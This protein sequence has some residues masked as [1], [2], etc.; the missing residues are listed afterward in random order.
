MIHIDLCPVTRR[1]LCLALTALTFYASALDQSQPPIRILVGAAPGGSTDTLPREMAPAMGRLLGRTVV[2]ENRA[3]AGGNL[4][5]EA[6]AKAAPDGNTLLVSFT[7]P[8]RLS[9][10]PEVPAG[11]PVAHAAA[12]PPDQP[13]IPA[14][15]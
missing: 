7:S 11:S 9:Q 6:V 15:A 1:T 3:G 4:A 8:K 2:I 14:C 5:A 12:Q 13:E 10:L